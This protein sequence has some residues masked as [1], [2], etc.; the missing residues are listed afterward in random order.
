MRTS[1]TILQRLKAEC[2][3]RT[4]VGPEGPTP[5]CHTDSKVSV[6]A[7]VFGTTEVVPSQKYFTLRSDTLRDICEMAAREE[8]SGAT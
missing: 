8:R 1:Q 2:N 3:C 5:G 7:V 4:Y 6:I